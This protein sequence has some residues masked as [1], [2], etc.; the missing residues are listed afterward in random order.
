MRIQLRG[1]NRFIELEA[2]RQIPI[3]STIDTRN[4]RVTLTSADGSGGTQTAD[5]YEGIFRVTQT[6]GARPVTVLTLTERLSC[7]R[8]RAQRGAA[9]QE[10]AQ[11]VG[12][13]P[14]PLPDR[15]PVQRGDRARHDLADA[16]PLRL[17]ADPRHAGLGDGAR[18]RQ[19]QD[20]RRAPRRPLHGPREPSVSP[21][22]LDSGTPA[23]RRSRWFASAMRH[24]GPGGGCPRGIR[25]ACAARGGAGA[26]RAARR[27]AAERLRRRPGRD[28]GASGRR[29]GR[30]LLRPGREPRARR[31]RD[32]GRRHLLPAGGRLRHRCQPHHRRAADGRGPGRR[33]ARAAHAPT[34]SGRTCA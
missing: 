2:G 19:A 18:P 13:R 26:G 20:R 12:Q 4:G 8:G 24:P 10:D 6:R 14:R 32:Q 23:A 3:G 5:F 16:G 15:R 34:R 22:R 33:H 31:A 11:A 9:R 27:R 30:A 28:P 21:G 29:R 25:R 7:P 1:T 17:D